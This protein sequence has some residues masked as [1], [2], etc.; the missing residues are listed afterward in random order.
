[1]RQLGRE[2]SSFEAGET[3]FKVGKDH[4]NLGEL[5]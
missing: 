1:M 4:E 2:L 5:G 3:S